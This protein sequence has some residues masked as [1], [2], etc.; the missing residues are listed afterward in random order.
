MWPEYIAADI[1]NAPLNEKRTRDNLSWL[2]NSITAWKRGDTSMRFK[3]NYVGDRLD[4]DSGLRTDY[5]SQSIPE[6]VQNNS[7][8]TQSHDVSA[9]FNMQINKRGYFLK[10]KFTVEGVWENSRS[11]I[12][13]SLNSTSVSD[14][15]ISRPIMTSNWL[16]VTT[17]NFLN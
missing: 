17:R 7:L 1:V 10:D 2:A 4:Y 3:L 11:A 8:R 13:G 16:S 15:G 9:Q 14:A 6:F 12:T 5:F